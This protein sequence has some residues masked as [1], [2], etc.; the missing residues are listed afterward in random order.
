MGE[1]DA[2]DMKS[3]DVLNR[4]VEFA[5]VKHRNQER[6]STGIPYI[7]HPYMV[8]TLLQE[9]GCSL[10]VIVSGYLHDVLEDTDTST[11]EI[12]N[13]FGSKVLAIIEG[14]SEPSKE[15]TWEYRK[16]HSLNYLKYE[17][18]MEVLQVT[19]A[20]KL[21]N[22]RSMQQVYA[23]EKEAMWQ[24]FNRGWEDQKR[25]Y[26]AYVEVLGERINS[27]ALYPLLEAEVRNMFA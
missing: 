19:C 13:N 6:K 16:Q 14:C 21:H 24:H 10:E 17:A 7:T 20:D 18:T 9:A 4:A 15:H 3:I 5:A 26:Q 25:L 27:F 22:L 23:L 12:E 8:G 2:M 1:I 11:E